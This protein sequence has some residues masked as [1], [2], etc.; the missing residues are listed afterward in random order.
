MREGGSVLLRGRV[1]RGSRRGREGVVVG[2]W[3]GVE[4]G[5]RRVGEGE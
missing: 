5:S 1:E 3:E 2:E 4:R